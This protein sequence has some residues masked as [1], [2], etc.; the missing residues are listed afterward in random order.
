M[1]V[2]IRLFNEKCHNYVFNINFYHDIFNLN[3]KNVIIY[4]VIKY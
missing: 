2:Y 3:I 4:N 1:K